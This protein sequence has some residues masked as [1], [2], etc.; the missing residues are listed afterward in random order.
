MSPRRFLFALLALS[1]PFA[2]ADPGPIESLVE[3]SP[4]LPPG[5]RPPST[6]VRT[7]QRPTP[8]APTAASRV[9]L[10]GVVAA[11]G[12][13]QVSLRRKGEPRGV[14]LA[15]GEQLDDIRFVRFDLPGREAV[16]ETAGRRETI[17]LKP[18]AVSAMPDVADQPPDGNAN[19]RQTSASSP[20]PPGA[21]PDNPRVPVRRR[22]I[23]SPG[24]E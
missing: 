3:R 20:K 17:P 14:W 5:Y 13:I 23:V 1:G 6:E 9:E 19:Q 18:P 2:A 8:P 21:S 15:P 16:V 12:E 7:P 24:N 22:V 10:I 11:A 4:F